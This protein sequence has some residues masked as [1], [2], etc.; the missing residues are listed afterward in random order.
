MDRTAVVHEYYRCL[1]EG[2]YETLRS[3]LSDSFTQYRP[4]RTFES[5]VAFVA[6]MRDDRPMTD[7][8]H[9]LAD[10]LANDLGVAA[11]GTLIGADGTDVFAFIDVFRFD[12]AGAIDAIE[13]YS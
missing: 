13:T 6:F 3:H 5:P 7:T 8:T 1:D 11:H 9:Q 12:D 4:D 2:D 10:V